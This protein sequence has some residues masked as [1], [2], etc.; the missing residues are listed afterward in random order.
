LGPEGG[1]PGRSTQAVRHTCSRNLGIVKIFE[2][3]P[4]KQKSIIKKKISRKMPPPPGQRGPV[5]LNTMVNQTL[6]TPTHNLVDSLVITIALD[7]I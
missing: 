6:P 2:I 5:H 1:R 3:A 4:H 7:L